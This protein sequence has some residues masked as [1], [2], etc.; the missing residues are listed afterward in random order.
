CLFE[1]STKLVGLA[2][3]CME[4][5]MRLTRGD[6]F[7][8]TSTGPDRAL[9]QDHEGADL[10]GRTDVC[11]AAELPREAIDLDDAHVIAVPLPEEHHRA[12]LARFFGRRREAPDR[13]VLEDLVVDEVLHPLA[14]FVRQLLR[15]GE[16]KPKLVRAYR[17]ARLT[18]VVAE[19]VSQ[20]LVQEM[21]RGVIGHRRVADSPG[22]HRANTISGSEALAL[23]QQRLV[24]LKP[25]GI[26][27]L[28]TRAAPV[29]TLDPACVGYLA[30]TGHVERRFPQLGQE[31]PLADLFERSDL[32]EHVRLLETDE[33]RA[34]VCR[35]REFSRTVI[36]LGDRPTRPCALHLHQARELLLVY[37][38]APLARELARQLEREPV[39]V[40][41]PERVLARDVPTLLCGLLE[42]THATLERLAEP[43]L[44]RGQDA[45]NLVPVLLELRIALFHLLD[46]NVRETAEVRGLEAD[47]RGLLHCTANDAAH[48]VAPA[49]VGR[50]DTVGREKCHAAS[51]VGED[52]V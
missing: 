32:G 12:Q 8:A 28:G 49:F 42:E 29:V 2:H 20:R 19:H 50:R 34:E 25:I 1:L 21:R 51:V 16:V 13:D 31:E 46:H 5:R 22:H 11:P 10:R 43:F 24:V 41:E 15:M 36:V 45:M 4:K 26:A 3:P 27:E 35:L 18:N 17:R 7:D 48:D 47:A 40:M 9:A 23:E 44:L 6:R 37:A 38:Q 14:L 30:A 52:A 33:L 39:R